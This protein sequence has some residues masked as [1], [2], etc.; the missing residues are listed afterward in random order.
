MAPNLERKV[1]FTPFSLNSESQVYKF[2]QNGTMIVSQP[3]HFK[4][5]SYVECKA[6]NV[7][8]L[9][10]LHEPLS[11]SLLF[12]MQNKNIRGLWPVMFILLTLKERKRESG[13]EVAVYSC[14]K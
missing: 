8:N 5:L 12:D 4:I 13:E 6:K 10:S 2:N 7:L 14:C 11:H 1:R 9:G 3:L